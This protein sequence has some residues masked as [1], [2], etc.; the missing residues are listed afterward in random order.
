MT[1]RTSPAE[2]AMAE[3][4]PTLREATSGLAEILAHHDP[5]GMLLAYLQVAY[6]DGQ[7]DMIQQAQ[8]DLQALADEVD[9]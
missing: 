9:E 2:G 1:D 5:A 7:R 8:H 6:R 3:R 4:R